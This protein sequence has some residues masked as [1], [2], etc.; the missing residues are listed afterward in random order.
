MKARGFWRGLL[1][2]LGIIFLWGFAAAEPLLEWEKT[3]SGTYAAAGYSVQQTSDG[4][5]I[6]AG[7]AQIFDTSMCDMYLIKTDSSGNEVWSKTFGGTHSDKGY[8]VQQTTDGG[9]IVAGVTSSS[10]AGAS[11]VYL[12]K[13][14]SS[15]NEVWSKTFGGTSTDEGYSVRQT[16]D[17]GYI[18][19]GWS[20][21]FGAGSWDVYLVKTD[22]LGNL[23]W[24]KTFGGTAT[25][26]GHSVQQTSDGGYIIAGSTSSFGAGNYD[27]YL[28]KTDSSGN[29]VWSKTFGG[30]STD[31]G[32]SVRQ[33]TDRGYIIAGHTSSF[34][35]GHYDI[36]LIKTDSS[37]N[38]VWSKTFGG[39]GTDE[40]YSVR[41]TLDGGY[42][43]AGFTESFGAGSRDVYL[44]KTDPWGNE[45]WSKTFGGTGWDYGYSVQQT[46][47]GGYII[48]GETGADYS[49]VYLIKL[50]EEP[51]LIVEG[52][53]T[54]PLSPIVGQTANVT[55]T[56]KNQGGTMED[57]F[58]VDFYKH[59]TSPPWAFAGDI[60][61]YK[62]AGLAADTTDTCTGTVVYDSAGTFNMWAQIDTDEE[63]TEANESNNIFGPQNIIV[64]P[65]ISVSLT[66]DSTTIP[67]GGTLGYTV[68]VTNNTGATQTFKYWTHV[69][70]PNGSKYPPAGEL[71]GPVTVRLNPGQTKN[72]HLTQSVP[73]TAPL[74]TYT[75]KGFV[76]P[77]PDIW[78]ED[79]FNFTV[80]TGP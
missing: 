53:T 52:I 75:Y 46:S 48:A 64:L 22:S 3:F 26:Y 35:A 17:G 77:Y 56:F 39:T 57:P 37:G 44:V 68:A 65:K 5:Y 73:L 63:V 69:L 20:Q 13:T 79:Q 51:D 31:E 6:I 9:Y 28:I 54:S 33:T 4:G 23:V 42:I 34:G 38:E 24:S 1:I 41:Q 72:A 32:Y 61:C 2:L 74:G 14:D 59:L 45:V 18:I 66:P 7:W 25:D 50:K 71:Y 27:V 78:D 15:G 80:T 10:G 47:D 19:A 49:D 70:L 67:R 76:G 21:S 16:L 43:I 36:Y 62:T 58:Y 55:L 12:V 30:T 11:D 60:A 8:S 40:G 29:E